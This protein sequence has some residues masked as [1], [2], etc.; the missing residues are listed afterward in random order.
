MTIDIDK[1]FD[2]GW[3]TTSREVVE[4]IDKVKAYIKLNSTE[5][6]DM[7]LYDIALCIGALEAVLQYNLKGK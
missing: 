2:Q 5:D 4:S 6:S 3:N 1:I 7:P